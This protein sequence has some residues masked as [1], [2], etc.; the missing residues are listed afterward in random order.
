MIVMYNLFLEYILSINMTHT[1]FNKLGLFSSILVNLNSIKINTIIMLVSIMLLYNIRLKMYIFTVYIY[2]IIINVKYT[3]FINL[4]LF[5]LFKLHT[6]MFY[7]GIM[8][9]VIIYSKNYVSIKIKSHT[10]LTISISAFILGSVWALYTYNW[11]YYW[12]NDSIEYMLLLLCF[13][14]TVY[15]HSINKQYYFVYYKILL[16]LIIIYF[17]R[18][19]LLYTK[20]NFFDN[21]IIYTRFLKFYIL[22]LLFLLCIK[23]NV[24]RLYS[25]DI[26]WYNWKLLIFLIFICLNFLN[27]KLIKT[28]TYCL[29][30]IIVIYSIYTQN[31]YKSQLVYIHVSISIIF[32]IFISIQVRYLVSIDYNFIKKN[33]Y[34]NYINLNNY[35][36]IYFLNNYILCNIIEYINS[37]SK[38]FGNI[39]IL[40][41][42]VKYLIN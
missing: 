12:S 17:L 35:K 31:W 9:L 24:L 22:F 13:L 4:F 7:V 14:Y 23:Y 19:G 30:Y 20:H 5:G 39:G 42:R 38:E 6:P 26:S 15:I 3:Y 1:A 16:L 29:F 2:T 33:T 41:N 8:L 27:Y 10:S 11:G 36:Q 32:I 28:F 25:L 40:L 18:T 37:N 34:T 21:L